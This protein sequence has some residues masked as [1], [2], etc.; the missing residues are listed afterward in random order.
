M[1]QPSEELHTEGGKEDEDE[2]HDDESIDLLA[3]KRLPTLQQ[4]PYGE[5]ETIWRT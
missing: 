4:P 1:F 2:V 3:D 5:R